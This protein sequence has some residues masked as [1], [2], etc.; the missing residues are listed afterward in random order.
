MFN[1][2]EISPEK[3]IA[4]ISLHAFIR[5]QNHRKIK[6]K[7]VP[8]PNINIKLNSCNAFVKE[9]AINEDIT[10]KKIVKNLAYLTNFFSEVTIGFRMSL[11]KYNAPQFK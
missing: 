5:N 9:R 1:I 6:I 4:D 8:A 7:P 2:I 10:N 3:N 11:T